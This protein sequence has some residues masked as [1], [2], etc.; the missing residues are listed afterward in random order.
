MATQRVKNA[1]LENGSPDCQFL[2]EKPKVNVTQKSRVFAVAYTITATASRPTTTTTTTVL[3]LASMACTR[4]WRHLTVIWTSCPNA[5]S[6]WRSSRASFENKLQTNATTLHQHSTHI[7]STTLLS[8]A[9]M[10]KDRSRNFCSRVT[11]FP[12]NPFFLSPLYL[13]SLPLPAPFSL[14]KSS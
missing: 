14:P 8:Q 5:V 12:S 10:G 6:R 11:L 1:G 4:V 13:F 9:T 2:V 7:N 3:Y